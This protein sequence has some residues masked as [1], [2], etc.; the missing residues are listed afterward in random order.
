LKQFVNS[1]AGPKP[2]CQVC[3]VPFLNT[4]KC[5]EHILNSHNDLLQSYYPIFLGQQQISKAFDTK[6]NRS[7]YPTLKAEHFAT[8]VLPFEHLDFFLQIGQDITEKTPL[9]LISIGRKALSAA[10]Y[11][12][13]QKVECSG[14][15]LAD[16]TLSTVEEKELTD[17]QHFLASPIPLSDI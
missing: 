13:I 8:I 9:Y 5:F 16:L 1:S 6:T 2:H 3:D 4:E 10:R 15:D 12:C 11:L 14:P 17:T 7:Y